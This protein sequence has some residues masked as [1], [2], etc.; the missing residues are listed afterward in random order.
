MKRA[1]NL[2]LVAAFALGA[3]VAYGQDEKKDEKKDDKKPEAVTAPLGFPASLDLKTKCELDDEQV[4]KI[5]A[6]YADY[7]DRAADI[8]KR[9][10]DGDK[11]AK[12]DAHKLKV[13]ISAKIHDLGKDDDQKKKIDDAL[14]KS[15]KKKANTT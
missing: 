8:Q 13:E 7:K 12:K 4:K 2:V 3:G 10:D 6:I 9:I 11:K 1:L 15:K 5:D 14:P